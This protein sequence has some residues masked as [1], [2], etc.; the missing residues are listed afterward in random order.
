MS[1]LV[2]PHK[3]LLTSALLLAT[4]ATTALSTP[5]AAAATTQT[6]QCVDG[7]GIRWT[8]KAVWSGTYQ[9]GGTRKVRL[10][11]AGWTTKAQKVRTDSTVRTYS[12]TGVLLQTLNRTANKDY[13]AG[14]SWDSRNPA[15]PADGPGRSSVIIKVGRDGDGRADCTVRFVQPGATPKPTPTPKPSVRPTPTPTIKPTPTRPPTPAAHT[16]PLMGVG[17]GPQ[18]QWFDPLN[19]PAGP[20]L[21]RR[22]YDS[23]LPSSF[24][25][26]AAASD[27][28]AKRASVW[29]YKPGLDFA[30]NTAKKAAFSAFL[31]TIPA[32]HQVFVILHHEPENDFELESEMRKW[33][34]MQDAADAIVDAKNRDNIKFGPCLM[35]PW[36]FDSRSPYFQWYDLWDDIMTWDFDFVGIDAY[37]TI[38]DDAY[39]LERML[40]VKNSGAGSNGT[41]LSMIDKLVQLGQLDGTK[42]KFLMAE[43]GMYRKQPNGHKATAA[44]VNPF[45]EDQVVAWMKSSYDWYKRWNVSRPD[46]QWIAALW[47]NYSLTGSDNPIDRPLYGSPTYHR[48]IAAWKVIVADSKKR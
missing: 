46:N 12:P 42:T 10:D 27:V 39:T 41:H 40:T 2:Q 47:F 7:A 25:S 22:S 3:T 35:G 26:S 36:T 11:F 9:D 28:A 43:Y 23:A 6:G 38:D 16:K 24:A 1:T 48:K 21:I 29:S 5:S 19:A 44:T 17:G 18:A 31:D 14:S 15:N 30:T 33:G 13:N 8:A 4:V 45:P 34:A 32:G 37:R 20:M